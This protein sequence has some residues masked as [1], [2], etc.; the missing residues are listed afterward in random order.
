[1]LSFSCSGLPVG[2]GQSFSLPTFLI[3][4]SFLRVAIPRLR[5]HKG[6]KSL[7]CLLSGLGRAESLVRDQN[8]LGQA[9]GQSIMKLT[10][11]GF[12]RVGMAKTSSSHPRLL[13]SGAI[14]FPSR[15]KAGKKLV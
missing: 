15:N 1:M 13:K 12:E 3:C 11:L 10:F 6:T 5:I 7:Y 14:Y 4:I 8:V 2:F 9:R